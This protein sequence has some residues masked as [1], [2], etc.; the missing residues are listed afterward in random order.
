MC[1]CVAKP[2]AVEL[3]C[4]ATALI[5]REHFKETWYVAL[6]ILFRILLKLMVELN[7]Q[8]KVTEIL[9][10]KVLNTTIAEFEPSHQDLQMLPSSL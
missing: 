5:V 3:R 4:H 2:I 10:H 9:T 8:Q 6:S 1:V 7:L